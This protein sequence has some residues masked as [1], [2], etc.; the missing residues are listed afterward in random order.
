MHIDIKNYAETREG[1]KI[2]RAIEEIITSRKS[3]STM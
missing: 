3:G 2:D 1:L